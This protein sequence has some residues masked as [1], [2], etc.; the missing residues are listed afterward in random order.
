VNEKKDTKR[1]NLYKQWKSLKNKTDDKK[2]EELKIVE[3][4][5]AEKYAKEHFD[6]IKA[7]T[8]NIDCEDGGINSGSLQKG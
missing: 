4:E 6:K 3:N 8:G 7:S 2:K 1:E 5:L